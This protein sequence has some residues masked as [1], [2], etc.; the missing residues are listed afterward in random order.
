[1]LNGIKTST[2]TT[3]QSSS[4]LLYP[5]EHHL[6]SFANLDGSGEGWGNPYGRVN[7]AGLLNEVIARLTASTVTPGSGINST[8]DDSTTTFPL[9]NSIY[10]D[11][12]HDNNMVPL[13]TSLGIEWESPLPTEAATDDIP[14]HKFVVSDVVPFAA[15][16][17]IEKLKSVDGQTYV[18]MIINDK[19]VPWPYEGCGSF[20]AMYGMCEIGAWLDAQSFVEQDPPVWDQVSDIYFCS[21]QWCQY[22]WDNVQD[23]YNALQICNAPQINT[24]VALQA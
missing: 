20:G 24:T 5:T 11:F 10:A 21:M 9:T 18:R 6:P 3:S 1:M 8:L 4:E 22:R 19:V 2:S 14:A 12:T 7:A 13:L 16:F 23:A 17:I 15:R